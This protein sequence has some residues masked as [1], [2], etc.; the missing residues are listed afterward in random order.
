MVPTVRARVTL[1]PELSHGRWPNRGRYMPHIV[2]GDPNQREARIGR[3][4]TIN[5]HYLGVLVADAP[6]ELLPG[7]TADVYFRLMYWPEEQYRG[8]VVG[9]TFTIREGPNVV[10]FGEIV[11]A[12]NASTIKNR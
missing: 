12:A 11:E 4:N 5:E 3:G 2:M 8:V 9:A 6:D 7:V 10:G 1:L